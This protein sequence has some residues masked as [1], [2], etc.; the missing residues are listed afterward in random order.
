MKN[1]ILL[2]LFILLYHTSFGQQN[3]EIEKL[4][5]E[6]VSLH[7][8]GQYE[9]A[10]NKY[11]KVLELDKDNIIALAEKSFSLLSL[12]KYDESISTCLKAI[13]K[14]PRDK[15][16]K[17]VFVTCGNAYD[18]IKKTEKSI[19][20]Y[21]KGIEIFP[22]YYSLH[23][24][25]G[26]TLSNNSKFDEAILS[27]QKS[28][29]SNPNHTSSQNAIARI[30]ELKKNRIPAILAYCRFLIVEPQTKRASENLVRLKNLMTKNVEKTGENAINLNIDSK[31]LD[32]VSSKNKTQENNFS[33]TDMVLSLDT[34]LDYDAKNANN[35]EIEQFIRKF[36][37]VCSSLKETQKNNYGFYWDYYVPYFIEMQD[38]KLVETFAYISFSS[39]QDANINKWLE[40]H[41]KDINRFYEWSNNYSWLKK[42]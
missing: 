20:M 16:L 32:D 22:D 5:K 39:S 18:G 14:N 37:T 11:D 17:S 10:I 33:S 29:I 41:E 6:G 13:N 1:K 42:N 12:K 8:K 31:I 21:D 2:L 27:F 36:S 19:E 23:F 7:D 40:N 15:N 26:I 30:N 24:N 25:K 3:E 38:K 35:T 4:I 9:N 34:A 28:A